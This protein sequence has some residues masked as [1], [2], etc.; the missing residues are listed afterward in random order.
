[1]VADECD[2]ESLRAVR[3]A[4]LWSRDRDNSGLPACGSKIR[5]RLLFKIPSSPLNKQSYIKAINRKIGYSH[6]SRVF[7]RPAAPAS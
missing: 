2:E 7:R 5:L 3:S 4:T 1:M 6:Q